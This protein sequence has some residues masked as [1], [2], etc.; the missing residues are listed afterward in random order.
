ME[1]RV[2]NDTD[3]VITWHAETDM[4]RD[5]LPNQLFISLNKLKQTTLHLTES[6]LSTTSQS[7]SFLSFSAHNTDSWD[8]VVGI[9][10]GYGLDDHG[11][12]FESQWGRQ[13]SLHV[14]QA[15]SG[16]HP[17]SYIMCTGESLPGG[18]AA[19]A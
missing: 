11:S 14:V 9:A 12:G 16:G 10:T 18:K 5:G 13:F 19:E 8:N 2:W 4:D 6:I 17:T 15:G 3:T 1:C 7:F